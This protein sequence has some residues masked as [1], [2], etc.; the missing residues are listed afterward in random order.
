MYF[1]HIICFYLLN[2]AS[3]FLAF[4]FVIRSP[5]IPYLTP[6]ST[7]LQPHFCPHHTLIPTL[8]LAPDSNPCSPLSASPSS[9]SRLAHT[10]MCTH[11]TQHMHAYTA[12][13]H[14]HTN[15]HI[16]TPYIRTQTH[17]TYK[18]GNTHT[19]AA[20]HCQLTCAQDHM[21]EQ[22]GKLFGIQ[23][24]V[25][26]DT[27]IYS[28]TYTSTPIESCTYTSTHPCTSTH[29]HTHT[30][31]HAPTCTSTYTCI[32]TPARLYI[33]TL[34]HRGIFDHASMKEQNKCFDF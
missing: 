34:A 3:V 2:R 33:H 28:H 19:H 5:V 30:H 21:K 25:L 27:R 11:N 16:Q 1:C 15:T 32:D 10:Y 7:L 12:R 24:E 17:N 13:T 31:M 22:E 29:T 4:V 20:S 8:T 23:T 26:F 18:Q 14:K 6:T 9:A